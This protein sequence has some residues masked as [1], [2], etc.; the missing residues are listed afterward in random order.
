[1]TLR[2]CVEDLSMYEEACTARGFK[3]T[4]GSR[5]D[6]LQLAQLVQAGDAR[7]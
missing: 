5:P 2:G 7:K 1:L 4:A 3:D 6:P